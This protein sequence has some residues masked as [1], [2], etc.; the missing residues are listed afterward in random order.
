MLANQVVDSLL[1]DLKDV[2]EA[3]KL[4]FAQRKISSIDD[5]EQQELATA[6]L[7]IGLNVA[8]ISPTRTHIVL[9]VHG[10]RTEGIWQDLV[11]SKLSAHVA[12]KPIVVGFDYLDIF[13]FWLPYFFR[14]KSIEKIE[15][16]LRGALSDYH[17]ADLSIIA[18]SFGTYIIAN[19][20]KR[21]PDI[22]VF[23][24]L[25]CG[26]IISRSF[27]W[28]SLPRFPNGGVLNDVGSEDFLPA[29][30][31]SVS[32]GYGNTG[33]FGFRTGKVKDRY[34]KFAHS[35]FFT[36]SHIDSYWIPF[37]VDG[38]IVESSWNFKRPKPAWLLSILRFMP[39]KTF[40][41]AGFIYLIYKASL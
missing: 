12:V 5:P 16:E 24:L 14:A 1:N 39:I 19:I 4:A 31:Q 7:L 34:F 17:G 13:S 10:I 18:H 2:K 36:D 27:Q 11:A 6:F 40:V 26:S 35:D 29:L 21:R 22:Q 37:I 20:L 41:L 30:A 33:T 8:G 25:L 28:D 9:L 15:R 23:R 3:E 32:W 38:K